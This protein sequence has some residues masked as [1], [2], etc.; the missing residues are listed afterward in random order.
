M[1]KKCMLCTKHVIHYFYNEL[2]LKYS[3]SVLEYMLIY[4][5]NNWIKQATTKLK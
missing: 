1:H 4:I 3:C 2:N 5:I